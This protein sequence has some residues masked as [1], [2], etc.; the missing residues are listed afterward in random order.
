[1][2]K[3]KTIFKELIEK[4]IIV[5]G[6][7]LKVFGVFHERTVSIRTIFKYMEVLTVDGSILFV[8]YTDG[9]APLEM[10]FNEI[11]RD[12]DG[13]LLVRKDLYYSLIECYP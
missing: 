4:E 3:S 12:N 6:N 7:L 13:V 2:K 5:P 10:K 8:H 11:P 1:M 9:P